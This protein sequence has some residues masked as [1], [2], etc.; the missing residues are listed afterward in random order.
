QG[1]AVGASVCC[2]GACLTVVAKTKDGFDVQVSKETLAHTTLGTW[3][4]G[5]RVNLERA[6]KASDEL[7]GHFVTGHVDGLATLEGKK[8]SGASFGLTF[9]APKM[10]ACYIA[11]K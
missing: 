2:S 8:K 1:L 7:G 10:L 5:T 11:E 4:K 3:K 6:M 9:K